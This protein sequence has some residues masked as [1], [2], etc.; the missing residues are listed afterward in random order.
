MPVGVPASVWRR[1]NGNGEASAISQSNITTLSGLNIVTLGGSD[2]VVDAGSFTPIP[3]S[4]W[5]NIEA[6]PVSVWRQTDGN[7][8]FNSTG[9]FDIVD[10]LGVY[11]V[12]TIGDQIV[13]T[14]SELSRK[15]YTVW[16]S[17]DSI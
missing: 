14:G 2:L 17:D 9:V 1:T 5:S 12:D 16:E 15:P 6:I 8:E 4:V 11:L 7:G 13:D 3:T 10:T